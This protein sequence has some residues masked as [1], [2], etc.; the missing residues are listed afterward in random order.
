MVSP[1]VDQ[2]TFPHFIEMKTVFCCPYPPPENGWEN[3]DEMCAEE[4]ADAAANESGPPKKSEIANPGRYL[5]IEMEFA[6][7]GD[8]EE[9]IKRQPD[10]LLPADVARALLFQIAIAL[11]VAA[12]EFAVNH[13]DVKL[14][15]I[16]IHREDENYHNLVLR[17]KLGSH[18]Y[19]LHMP[20]RHVFVAKLA[21][22]GT[23]NA[24]TASNDVPVPVTAAQFT[25]LENTPPDYMILG[26]NATQGHGHD[27]FGLGLCMLHLFT[28]FRPYEEIL[29]KVKCPRDLN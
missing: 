22:F 23:A 26:D 5:Y 17:Y 27:S 2:K 25:T 7:E 19:A 3:K 28:G 14:L 1:L 10:E 11:Y 24:F 18:V 12:V 6:N 16:F 29:K 15:N 13:Y 4:I 21:D 9:L 8:A 20:P